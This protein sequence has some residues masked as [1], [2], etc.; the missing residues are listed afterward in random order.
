MSWL[1]NNIG[2][3]NIQICR[4]DE[5]L[6]REETVSGLGLSVASV[7]QVEFLISG[8]PQQLFSKFLTHFGA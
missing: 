1:V 7:L 8:R 4:G 3:E 5:L 2:M 6:G